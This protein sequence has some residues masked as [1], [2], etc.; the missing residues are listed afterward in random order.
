MENQKNK[1]KPK[2]TGKWSRGEGEGVF[3]R[4]LWFFWFFW[5]FQPTVQWF[6]KFAAKTIGLSALFEIRYAKS[7]DCR[8][9]LA[10]DMQ[11]HWTVGCFWH[12]VCKF[13]GLSC[14]FGVRLAKSLDFLK[15]NKDFQRKTCASLSKTIVVEQNHWFP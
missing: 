13:I 8:L 14:V 4:N 7:L 5:N 6:C 15:Q 1:K 10:S 3:S 9:F 2:I 12:Q 11:I